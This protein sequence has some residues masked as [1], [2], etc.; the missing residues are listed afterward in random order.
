MDFNGKLDAALLNLIVNARDAIGLNR[1]TISLSYRIEPGRQSISFMVRDS[2]PGMSDEVLRRSTEPFFTT[3]DVGSGSGLGLSMVKGFAEQTGG[4]LR[5]VNLGD[6][7]FEAI[8]T[9]PLGR[10]A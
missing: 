3:K 6:E 5:L 10:S 4:A 7:G 9:L 2:G 8:V 1:G